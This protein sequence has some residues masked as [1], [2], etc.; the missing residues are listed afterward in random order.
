MQK[1]I[2]DEELR[3]DKV[4]YENFQSFLQFIFGKGSF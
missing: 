4:F 3:Q 1:P 2:Q